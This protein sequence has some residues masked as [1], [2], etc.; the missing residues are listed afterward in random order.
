MYK[1]IAVDMDGTLL[2]ED[3]TISE[4][5]VKA[6]NKA[7][8]KGVRVV[9]ASGRPIEGLNRY[10][11]ELELIS[12]EDYVLSYNGA[13]VQNTATKEIISRVV[14]KGSDLHY[15]H[16]LSNELGVNIHA[17]STEQGLI[18]PKM[19][20]YT[21]VEATINGI[22]VLER[23][24]DNIDNETEMVKIMMIDEPEILQAAIDK[25][26]KEV[27]EKYTVVRSAPFF[28]EFLN[29]EAN[30]GEGVKALA[31]NLGLT[32]EQVICIGDAGNDLHMIQFAGLGVAM[33]NAFE[34]IKEIADYITKSNE[35]D[36]VAH[37]IEKFVIAG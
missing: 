33:G 34:E 35:E 12:E 24:F 32:K 30:K 1:L 21:E 18:T 31:E 16:N 20:K 37:V 11:T 10:L 3:K 13:L 14:L 9:L 8:A 19:N 28:L 17:F 26:P 25:L 22:D 29:K 5:T 7:R 15:L 27:Y 4:A 23:E 6:I 2:K 36:G